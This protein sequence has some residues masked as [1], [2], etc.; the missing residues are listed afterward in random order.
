MK[1]KQ[2]C[3][4]QTNKPAKTYLS[5]QRR[6]LSVPLLVWIETNEKRPITEI[7]IDV[8]VHVYEKSYSGQREFIETIHFEHAHK[9]TKYSK[10]IC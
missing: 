10:Y 8:L 7:V 1:K 6:V 2:S 5:S 9:L 3:A 4:D